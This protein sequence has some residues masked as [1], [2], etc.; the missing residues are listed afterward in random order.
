MQKRK[1]LIKKNEAFICANCG[2][3]NTPAVRTC[4]NHCVKCL[5]SL[6]IDGEVPG[7]RSATCGGKMRPTNVYRKNGEWFVRHE[8]ELCS[9]SRPNKILEDDNFDQVIKLSKPKS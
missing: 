9:H 1:N 8:C 2:F 7:D 4:R 5:F 3:A 6:H